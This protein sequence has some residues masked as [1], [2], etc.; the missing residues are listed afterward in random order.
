MKKSVKTIFL[1]FLVFCLALNGYCIAPE[2]ISSFESVTTQAVTGD[3]LTSPYNIT[4]ESLVNIIKGMVDFDIEGSSLFFNRKTGQLFVKHTPSKHIVI[5][6]I[7][8]RMRE[9]AFKQIEIEARLISIDAN[10]FEGVG[11]QFLGADFFGQTG[12]TKL[13]G[14][15]SGLLSDNTYNNALTS[16][17]EFVDETTSNA[18]GQFSFHAFKDN[19][20]I[21]SIIEALERKVSVNTL[22]CP[23]L[24]V[25]NNQRANIKIQKLQNFLSEIEANFD[26]TDTVTSTTSIWFQVETKVRQAETGTVLDVTPCINSDGTIN[27]EL[28][29]SY[30]TADLTTT[31]TF[32]NRNASKN[33]ENEVTLPIFTSQGIDT[34][35]T[36]PNGGVAAIGGLITENETYAHKKV[37]FFGDI[38][39]IGKLLFSQEKKESQRAYVIIFIKA[40]IKE[41]KSI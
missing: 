9:A 11:A 22:A 3:D 34:V 1:S 29:P 26:T 33:F 39:G 4:G 13:G 7:I 24:V 6:D 14:A 31:A 32:Q 36:V 38:P 19:I 27:L 2:E 37:P 41:S 10:E 21:Q 15:T 17:T 28:H 30:V 40:K 12:N 16:F 25:F 18:G 23:R 5:E 20:D 8:N 35:L